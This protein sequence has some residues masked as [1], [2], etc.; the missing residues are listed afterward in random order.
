[1]KE[2]ALEGA[3][4]DEFMKLALDKGWESAI[5]VDEENAKKLQK[6]AGHAE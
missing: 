5:S 3:V 4:A 2:I 1:M 6:Y